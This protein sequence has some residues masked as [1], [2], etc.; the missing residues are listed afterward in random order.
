MIKYLIKYIEN[1]KCKKITKKV[2]IG[3]IFV[4]SDEYDYDDISFN[5]KEYLIVNK[6]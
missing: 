1:K 4:S 3:D 2:F 5:F 6:I